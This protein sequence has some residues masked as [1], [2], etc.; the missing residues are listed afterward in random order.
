MK[1]LLLIGL[2]LWSI[3]Q[4][5]GQ[6][7]VNMVFSYDDNGNRIRNK[8]VFTKIQDKGNIHETESSFL[9]SVLDTMNSV[10]I[11]IYPNP[12]ND[13]VVVATRGMENGQT[14]KAMLLSITGK[15]LEER[16]IADTQESFDLSEK[17][18]GVYLLELHINQEKQIWKVIKR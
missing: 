2:C 15:V 13:K 10:E 17:A 14:L 6:Y 12:T 3:M 5:Y 18:S 1:R 4:V 7:P 8:I 11:C 9:T 16:V